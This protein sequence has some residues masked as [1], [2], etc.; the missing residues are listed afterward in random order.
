[1][2]AGH[3]AA[4]LARVRV[5]GPLIVIGL[6]ASAI[7][8]SAPRPFPL[9][10]QDPPMEVKPPAAYLTPGGPVPAVYRYLRSLPEGTVVAELPFTEL[11]YNTRYL[12]FSTYHW[13]PLVNGFTSFFPPAFMEEPL[14]PRRQKVATW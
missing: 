3:G 13:K 2:L 11:W 10:H 1:M 12:L 4:L 5:I 6:A 9:D 8:L 14:P 7:L